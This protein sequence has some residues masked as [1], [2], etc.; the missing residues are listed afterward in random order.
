MNSSMAYDPVSLIES[1]S[2]VAEEQN[3]SRAAVRL[4]I[5][6]SALTRRIQKLEQSV[7]FALF[8]R[9]TREVSLTAAGRRF[10]EDSAHFLHAFETS[11]D[12]AKRIAEGKTGALR[13]AYMA[14]AAIN[15][16]PS[17]LARFR[18]RHPDVEI[19]LAYL[20]TQAQ[21]IALAND[22]IDLGFLIGP[23]DHDDFETRV[24]V[25]DP[26]CLAMPKGHPLSR[27]DRVPASDLASVELILGNMREWEAYRWRI[28]EL[29]SGQGISVRVKF[30]TPDTPALAGLVAS[31][32]GVTI[33]PRSL[34]EFFGDKVEFRTIDHP[35]FYVETVLAWRRRNRTQIVRHFVAEACATIGRTGEN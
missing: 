21:K 7:G 31:G 15:L 3:F 33:C 5:D 18:S 34:S 1:F 26:L 8:D 10:Y 17:T 12:A 25:A 22:E 19:E 28:S 14:F 23:F 11:V 24:L 29:L 30:E 9:T 20:P 27:A 35:G 6:R 2:T 13:I 32:M 4:N 16:M